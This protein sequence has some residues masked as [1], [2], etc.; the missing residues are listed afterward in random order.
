MSL[1]IILTWTLTLKPW[2]WLWNLFTCLLLKDFCLNETA[3]ECVWQLYDL[4]PKWL[5]KVFKFDNLIILFKLLFRWTITHFQIATITHSCISHTAW[6]HYKNKNKINNIMQSTFQYNV[7][8]TEISKKKKWV[9][10]VSTWIHIH[11][12]LE[13]GI[14]IS[15]QH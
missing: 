14:K 15:I 10:G 7:R 9:T 11:I 3:L 2:T 1:L 13:Q 6:L 4:H 8:I 12:I 5:K